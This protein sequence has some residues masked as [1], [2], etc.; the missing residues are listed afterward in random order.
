MP[1]ML[2]SANICNAHIWL[3]TDWQIS[4]HSLNLDYLQQLVDLFPGRF[5]AFI[6]V[7]TL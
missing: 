3:L 7:G 2:L 5:S 1:Q 4:F 6:F